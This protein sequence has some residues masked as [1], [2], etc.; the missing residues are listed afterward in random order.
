MPLRSPLNPRR[1]TWTW[2]ISAAMG[3]AGLGLTF[4]FEEPV[5]TDPDR[6]IRIMLGISAGLFVLSR[7]LI[8]VP[9]SGLAGRLRRWWVDY[10]LIVAAVAWWAL[11]RSKTSVILELGAL[12]SVALGAG[13]VLLAGFRGLAN[14]GTYG[15]VRPASVR[16]LMGAV[17]VA[18]IGGTVL[19]LPVCWDGP[20]PVSWDS[21]YPGQ[22]RYELARHWLD[23]TFTATAALTCTGL[24]VHDIGCEFSRIGQAVLLLLMHVGGLAVLAIGVSICWRLRSLCGWGAVDDDTS[25]TGIS[26]LIAFVIVAALILEAIGTAMLYGM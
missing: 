5:V 11:D 9:A 15:Q 25:P 4:G 16:L 2:S 21:T 8:L 12:Y 10:V 18:L 26:R 6:V 20:Y 24:A 22:M 7:L 3:L 1:L 23:C 13:A 14:G 17:V 19:A